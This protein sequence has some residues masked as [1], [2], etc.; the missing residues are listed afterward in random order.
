MSHM[1][2]PGSYVHDGYT[3]FCYCFIGIDIVAIAVGTDIDANAL[4]KFVKSSED[5]IIP[6]SGTLDDEST[7]KA[8]VER[9]C[10]FVGK[11]T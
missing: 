8:A 7:V 4:R 6:Q 11:S 9:S 5:L 3:C 1:S 2:P 10:H